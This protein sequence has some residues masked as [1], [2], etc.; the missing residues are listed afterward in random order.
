MHQVH[1]KSFQEFMDGLQTSS[2]KK[3]SQ[4]IRKEDVPALIRQNIARFEK[5]QI[6]AAEKI[7]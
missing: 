1:D 2:A 5:M 3:R 4:H 6:G 7:Y